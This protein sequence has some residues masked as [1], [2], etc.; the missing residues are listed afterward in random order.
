[1]TDPDP[2]IAALDARIEELQA[3]KPERQQAAL[4]EAIERWQADRAAG[5]PLPPPRVLSPA[6]QAEAD[7]LVAA[8]LAYQER[9]KAL[10]E[11]SKGA[12]FTSGSELGRAYP[13]RSGPTPVRYPSPGSIAGVKD[14][15]GPA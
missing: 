7:N 11:A 12:V 9:K 5:V 14:D 3:A 1:M 13:S 2:L 8:I 10:I 4:V 15:R 6:E